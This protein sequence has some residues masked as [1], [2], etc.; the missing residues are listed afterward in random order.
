MHGLSRLVVNH[1]PSKMILFQPIF[2]RFYH[3]DYSNIKLLQWLVNINFVIMSINVELL[4]L[5]VLL[6]KVRKI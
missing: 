5:I 4:R 3:K 1:S 2:K 6:L